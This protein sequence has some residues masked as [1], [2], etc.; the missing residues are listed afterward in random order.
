[1]I[2]IQSN[3][4]IIRQK[5]KQLQKFERLKFSF[6]NLIELYK[7]EL[8]ETGFSFLCTILTN[9]YLAEGILES[10]CEKRKIAKMHYLLR[11]HL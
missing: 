6:L 10:S 3:I 7:F 8:Y 9:Y 1:M 11:S 2:C 5:E 4:I